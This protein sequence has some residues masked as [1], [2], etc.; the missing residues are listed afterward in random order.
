[1]TTVIQYI[2]TE[3]QSVSSL[4]YYNKSLMTIFGLTYYSFKMDRHRQNGSL[5]ASKNILTCVL[6]EAVG[7]LKVTAGKR[8]TTLLSLQF[9]LFSVSFSQSLVFPERLCSKPFQRI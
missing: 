5:F 9:L 8:V 1:M 6:K 3:A 7:G 4:D 2:L